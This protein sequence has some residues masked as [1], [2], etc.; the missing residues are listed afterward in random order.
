[1]LIG[2]Q[3][4]NSIECILDL[5]GTRPRSREVPGVLPFKGLPLRAALADVPYR[6]GLGARDASGAE[7]QAFASSRRG[8]DR[9]DGGRAYLGGPYHRLQDV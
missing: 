7:G 8:P 2:V 4:E 9:S 5:Q 3:R 1:M 6:R